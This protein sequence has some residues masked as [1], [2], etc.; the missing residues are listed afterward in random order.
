MM[1]IVIGKNMPVHN[2]PPDTH[3]LKRKG[4][5]VLR[6]DSRKNKQDRRESARDGVIV[7]F[8]FRK[9]R[10]RSGGRRDSDC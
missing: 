5:K 8:S 2:K 4:R 3:A 10:R 7:S 1:D 6:K 9:D